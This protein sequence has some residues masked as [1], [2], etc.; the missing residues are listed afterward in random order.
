MNEKES[1][2]L[3]GLKGTITKYK[4]KS[5]NEPIRIVFEDEKGIKIEYPGEILKIPA[6]ESIERH[7]KKSKSIKY[8]IMNGEIQ[9]SDS[10]F[11]KNEEETNDMNK[12]K[13]KEIE[14]E[15][16]F[17]DEFDDSIDEIKD[18][19]KGL[20]SLVEKQIELNNTLTKFMIENQSKQ[21]NPAKT[22]DDFEKFMKYHSFISNTSGAKRYDDAF[23]ERILNDNQRLVQE[24][25]K[26]YKNSSSGNPEDDKF[27]NLLFKYVMERTSSEQATKDIIALLETPTVSGGLSLIAEKLFGAKETQA[28]GT[29]KEEPA[30]PSDEYL[31]KAE[32]LK[33]RRTI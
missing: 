15:E 21:F 31:K 25:Q 30:K 33:K 28:L 26:A 9:I 2:Q 12:K 10:V 14:E 24:I 19:I 13:E 7:F 16:Y 18:S 8:Y 5:P 22:E 17:E 6:Y 29:G 11:L 32:E 4:K 1:D 20:T 3:K 23:I 27:K